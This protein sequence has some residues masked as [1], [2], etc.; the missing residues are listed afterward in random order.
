MCY[1]IVILIIIKV[2]SLAM[3]EPFKVVGVCRVVGVVII[4]RLLGGAGLLAVGWSRA[5][6]RLSWWQCG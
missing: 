6:D 3:F 1:S 2:V 4:A 5:V